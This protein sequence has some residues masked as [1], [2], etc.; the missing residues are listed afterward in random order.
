MI[1]LIGKMVAYEPTERFQTPSQL[2]EA[3]QASRAEV[4]REAALAAARAPTGPKTLYAVESNE[5]LK[6]AFRKLGQKVYKVLLSN[7][8]EM[9]LKQ[10]QQRPYHILIMDA[11]SVGREGVAAFN[12]VLKESDVAGLDLAA[13]LLLSSEQTDWEADAIRHNRAAVM[14]LPLN[15]KELL[16]KIRELTP[17]GNGR[18]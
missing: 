17:E 8:P 7:D 11:G 16:R 15:M 4:V 12:R 3:I 2:I 6:D 5:K 10:Y 18:A 13:V 9:A 1:S 14:Y